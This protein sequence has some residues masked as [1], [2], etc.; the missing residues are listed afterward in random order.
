MGNKLNNAKTPEELLM[1]RVR[2]GDREAADQL[3]QEKNLPPNF[4]D[5]PCGSLVHYACVYGWTDLVLQLLDTGIDV[6]T[7]DM[8]GD[9]CLNLACMWN[10]ED[11]ALKLLDCGANPDIKNTNGTI[12]VHAAASRGMMKVVSKI[13]DQGF[14]HPNITNRLNQTMLHC[15][16]LQYLDNKEKVVAQD[17]ILKIV[18]TAG[19][20]INIQ[21]YGGNTALHY[22]CQFPTSPSNA[23][24]AEILILKG[25]NTQLRN[26]RGLCPFMMTYRYPRNYTMMERLIRLNVPVKPPLLKENKYKLYDIVAEAAKENEFVTKV[27]IQQLMPR[28]GCLDG[29]KTYLHRACDRYDSEL[30]KLLIEAKFDIYASDT[31][32]STPVHEAAGYFETLNQMINHCQS[33][34]ENFDTS[35]GDVQKMI[36]LHRVGK[37]YRNSEDT[38]E[39]ILNI[40]LSHGGDINAIDLFGCTPF[41]YAC[42][43]NHPAWELEIWLRYGA[44]VNIADKVVPIQHLKC[45]L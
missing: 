39:K 19:F 43:N 33:L 1:I 29:G 36:P 26:D 2:K 20:D 27:L 45:Y 24:I 37:R 44:N 42:Q 12:A 40:H 32:G 22:A 30:I 9:T 18:D 11:L 25:A 34:N 17:M 5:L 23:D 13:L 38:F 7:T 28:T 8:R 35:R 31:N 15:F 4:F 14:S 21:D 10:H 41:H 6:N 16:L 3:L